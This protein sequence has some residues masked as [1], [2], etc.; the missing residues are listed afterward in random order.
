MPNRRDEESGRGRHTAAERMNDRGSSIRRNGKRDDSRR[1]R[2]RGSSLPASKR[3]VHSS[4]DRLARNVRDKARMNNREKKSVVSNRE[5]EKKRILQWSSEFNERRSRQEQARR[6]KASVPPPPY[7]NRH[8]SRQRHASRNRSHRSSSRERHRSSSSSSRRRHGSR[9]RTLALPPSST[10]RHG[11]RERTNKSIRDRSPKKLALPPIEKPSIKSSS[12]ATAGSTPKLSKLKSDSDRTKEALREANISLLSSQIGGLN[13]EPTKR[14]KGENAAPSKPTDARFKMPASFEDDDT[15]DDTIDLDAAVAKLANWKMLSESTTRPA[16]KENLSKS[17][18]AIQDTDSMHLSK[19][20]S[21]IL[22]KSVMDRKNSNGSDGR[23]KAV[24]FPRYSLEDSGRIFAEYNGGERIERCVALARQQTSS[25]DESGRRSSSVGPGSKSGCS[26]SRHGS[27]NSSKSERRLQKC[28][29]LMAD[30]ARLNCPSASFEENDDA[31]ASIEKRRS[32]SMDATRDEG[33]LVV[34]GASDDAIMMRRDSETIGLGS[35][36]DDFYDDGYMRED[37]CGDSQQQ[38]FNESI[39]V[40]HDTDTLGTAGLGSLAHRSEEDKTYASKQQATFNK[41]QDNTFN[42]SIDVM[43]DSEDSIINSHVV[44]KPLKHRVSSLND[45]LSCDTSIP[46]TVFEV[47]RMSFRA[48]ADHIRGDS[49]KRVSHID[50]AESCSLYPE[51]NSPPV[52]ADDDISGRKID[53]IMNKI[54][55]CKKKS[56][57]YLPKSSR[58]QA[59]ES[60]HPKPLAYKKIPPPPPRRANKTSNTM[61]SPPPRNPPPPARPIQIASITEVRPSPPNVSS[62]PHPPH[63]TSALKKYASTGV[64][65]ELSTTPPISPKAR[66][67]DPIEHIMSQLEQL[68]QPPPIQ[69]GGLR[70]SAIQDTCDQDLASPVRR[71]NTTGATPAR[72]HGR[73]DFQSGEVHDMTY[74]DTRGGHG[75]Y[76]G[77]V[78][79]WGRPHGEGRI[80][81]DSGNQ[82][83]GRWMNGEPCYEPSFQPQGFHES[84]VYQ[85]GTP[86]GVM[87]YPAAAPMYGGLMHQT[88]P[89]NGNFNISM[90]SFNNSMGFN[91]SMNFNP[92]MD[93]YYRRP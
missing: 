2:D 69:N 71:R 67:Q 68:G 64:I 14:I 66:K 33:V 65:P 46:D 31:S 43:K 11:S 6:E 55:K 91:N 78:D 89:Y 61:S 54:M 56:S 37:T 79:Q 77:E 50:S 60:K 1:N 9:D 49:G 22:P 88:A 7:R 13:L 16:E 26:V 84:A 19:D 30:P 25:S 73:S 48:L 41:S 15:H 27:D 10:T 57:Q 23:P 53:E 4:N 74:R 17:L 42:E 39:D 24:E 59:P 28:L 85:Q 12:N 20:S 76:S 34:R 35:M 70:Q 5:A 75:V 47:S 83:E 80:E 8:D 44:T 72:H 90:N 36:A 18:S 52:S 51:S 87:N 81:Y 29:S 62:R 32:L 86:S 82:F 40:I 3:N 58:H 63:N 92:G 93:P 45:C 21:N 38:T